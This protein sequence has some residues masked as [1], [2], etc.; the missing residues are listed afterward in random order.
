MGRLSTRCW[1]IAA[2]TCFHS[3]TKLLVRS[4]TDVGHLGLPRSWCSKVVQWGWGQGSMQA[5]H[6]FLH[7][8]QQSISVWTS[9]C[10]LSCWNR[11]GP[12]PNFFHKVGSTELFRMSLYAVV[13]R[14]PFTE[15]KG[16][17]PNHEKPDHYSFTTKLYRCHYALGQVAFSWL[18]PNPDWFVGLLLQP[19]LSIAHG[20][21]RLVC[22]CSAMETHFMKLPMNS[23]C[24]DVAIE[25]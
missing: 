16:P 5:S 21:H 12:S 6:V 18:L 19:T 20:D 3:A 10:T 24:A 13:L 14:F 1:N 11:K 7:Q 8:S 2:W 9:R 4:G 17:I 15:T 23:S 25:D 22:G